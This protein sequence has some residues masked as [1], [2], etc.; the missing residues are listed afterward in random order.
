MRLS[1]KHVKV[2]RKK[3]KNTIFISTTPVFTIKRDDTQKAR[4][5]AIGDLQGTGAFAEIDTDILSMKSL[6][7]LLIIELQR[8]HHIRA[9]DINYAPLY[10]EVD[11]E[12]YIAHPRDRRYVILLKKITLWIETRPKNWNYTLGGY[13]NGNEFYDNEF[14]PGFFMS[15]GW[16]GNDCS[17]C[18]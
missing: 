12:L 3:N 17:L 14:S 10:A 15:R 4:V 9:I 5:A 6:M 13:M 11:E 16:Y 2:P 1:G 7:L 18:G 8:S